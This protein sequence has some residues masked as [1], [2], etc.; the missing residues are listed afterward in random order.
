MEKEFI[1]NQTLLELLSEKIG[2]ILFHKAAR[3]TDKYRE[4]R[5]ACT[6]K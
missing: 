2:M 6:K 4:Q 3:K 1:A 5:G